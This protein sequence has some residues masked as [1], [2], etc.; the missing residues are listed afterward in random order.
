M[1]LSRKI[2]FILVLSTVGL[3]IWVTPHID[4]QILFSKGNSALCPFCRP[5]A[6]LDRSVFYEGPHSL[7]LITYKPAAE[8]HVLVIPKRHV[9]RFEELED[10]E[11]I[12]MK[13]TIQRIDQA[14]QKLYDSTS[15][16]LFQKNGKAAGQSVP[17]VHFH[18]IPRKEGESLLA[19]VIR[20]STVA[21]FKPMSWD[22]VERH[23]E[24]MSQYMQAL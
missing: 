5:S 24:I 14:S 22:E 19:L 17:H 1:K 11:L 13:Q 3:G 20:I 6:V 18:Y 2:G 12:D 15:Y 4:W 23:K 16:L 8:G 10:V 21:L 7:G 9:M